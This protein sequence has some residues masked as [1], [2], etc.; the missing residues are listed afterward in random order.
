MTL[1]ASQLSPKRVP[2]STS[3]RASH[4][5]AANQ[6]TMVCFPLVARE[7]VAAMWASGADVA[8]VATTAR[9]ITDARRMLALL[10]ERSGALLDAVAD[11]P[12]QLAC[13]RLQLS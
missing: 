6:Y 2:D 9:D 8:K 10:E 7:T 11:D 4:P 12:E 5:E 3:F 13:H 1:F